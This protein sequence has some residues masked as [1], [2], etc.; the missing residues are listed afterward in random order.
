[1]HSDAQSAIELAR[2][3]LA[4]QSE[5]A[6][7]GYALTALADGLSLRGE[8]EEAGE[9]YRDGVGIL[10]TERRWRAAWRAIP[11]TG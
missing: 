5:P 6:D 10:E 7:R 8:T 11:S 2:E 1:M 4:M 9:A 3:A